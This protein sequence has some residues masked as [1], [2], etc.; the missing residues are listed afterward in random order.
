[1]RHLYNALHTVAPQSNKSRTTAGQRFFAE[2]HA[3]HVLARSF[4]VA[5]LLAFK[6]RDSSE[7]VRPPK[8]ILGGIALAVCVL[9]IGSVGCGSAPPAP[10]DPT[11]DASYKETVAKIA[12]MSRDAD[13]DFKAGKGDDAAALI[14]R[15]QPLIKQVIEV[16]HP[17]LEAVEAAS[18]I[19]DLYGRMLLS[20]HHYG[21]ARLQFQKN[22]SRWKHWSPAT[23][24]T[25]R[26]L[27][28]AQEEI[29]ACDRK[30]VQ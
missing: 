1:M 10:H 22:L 7:R 3:L 30:I 18:D 23:P 16:N 27:K 26:R 24:E 15:A 19:D 13:T 9:A 2:Y 14:E 21:W 8:R 5:P 12:Q 4:A 20:N 11:Q 17:T 28:Q 25:E 6:R 29:D